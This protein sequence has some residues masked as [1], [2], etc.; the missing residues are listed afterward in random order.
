ML[1]GRKS[2]IFTL[3]SQSFILFRAILG[4][5]VPYSWHLSRMEIVSTQT[6]NSCQCRLV[7]LSFQGD[8]RLR[9]HWVRPNLP[10]FAVM[11]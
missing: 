3:Q 10:R 1:G 7:Y 6:R 9:Q 8:P 11:N 2:F 4:T 5:V